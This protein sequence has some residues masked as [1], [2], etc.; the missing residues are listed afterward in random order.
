[1]K[2]A[3]I[4]TNILIYDI[5]EDSLY[6]REASSVLDA[7]EEWVIPTIVIHELAWFMKGLG[8]RAEV[9]RDI[10]MQYIENER[11]IVKPVL[12][13]HIRKALIII[14]SE[15]LTLSRYNDK[16]ILAIAAEE[17]IPLAS[18]DRKLRS[19]AKKH[20]LDVIPENTPPHPSQRE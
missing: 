6:H 13:H 7:L 14:T 19:Q 8:L 12:A 2:R 10:I 18:L 17:K 16:L 3:V 15:G 20:G 1:M 11:T 4:D 9:S 5:F